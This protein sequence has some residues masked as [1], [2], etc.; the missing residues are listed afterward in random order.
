MTLFAHR[1]PSQTCLREGTARVYL[2]PEACQD[3]DPLDR[4]LGRVLT[5]ASLAGVFATD[6]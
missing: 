5:A 2:S 6:G 1:A 3:L 4:R